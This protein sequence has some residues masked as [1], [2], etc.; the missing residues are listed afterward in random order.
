M[1]RETENVVLLIV[2]ISV[3][4]VTIT[5][6]YTRYVK[7]GMLPWL[8]VSAVI[9]IGLAL[10]AMLRDIRGGQA[11]DHPGHAHRSG[12]VWLLVIPVVLLVFVVPPAL[13]AKA[14]P[15]ATVSVTEAQSFPPLPAGPSPTVALP[16]VLMRIAVGAVGGLDGKQITTTGFTMRDGER[17]YLAKIVIFCCAADAQLARLQLSGPAA[18]VAAGLPENTWVRVEGVV[19]PGQRYSGTDSVPTFEV[20]SVV[21]IDPPANTYG[22]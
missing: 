16:E 2:G 13:S 19:P 7:P 1:R 18:P 20:S 9:L 15:P 17:V 10:I 22:S 6:A 4:M 21:R 3:A 11:H 5:G 14:T 12:I 8:A